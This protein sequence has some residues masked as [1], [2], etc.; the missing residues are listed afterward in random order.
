MINK[1]KRLKKADFETVMKNSRVLSNDHLS[2]RFVVIPTLSQ[3]QMA[4]VIAKKVSKL[5]VKRHLLRRRLAGI[6]TN[7]PLTGAGLIF[8]VKKDFSSLSTPELAQT[9]IDLLVKAKVLE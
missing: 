8:F 9:T 6:L 3:P 7:L 1:Q 2:L 5:A 4:I